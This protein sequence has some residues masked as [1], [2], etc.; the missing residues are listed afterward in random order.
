[1][2]PAVNYHPNLSLVMDFYVHRFGIP[3]E[4][5]IA[6]TPTVTTAS[7]VGMRNGN[8]LG[9]FALPNESINLHNH[10]VL[11]TIRFGSCQNPSPDSETF[12]VP[13]AIRIS[14]Q[15]ESTGPANQS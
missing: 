9:P 2:F 4:K 3:S 8:Y 14:S 10:N 13:R 7:Y 1:L 5:L 15:P 6:Q 12:I 11:C